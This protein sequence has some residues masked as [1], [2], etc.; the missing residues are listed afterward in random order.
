MDDEAEH[1]TDKAA[2]QTDALREVHRRAMQRFDA[3]AI[4]TMENR[5][6]SLLARRF[7]TIP[8]AQWDGDWGVQFEKSI[9]VEVNKVGRGVDKIERDYRDNR[10]VPDFRPD[11]KEA[12]DETADTLDGMHRAD[13]YRF[14]SQQARDNAA[15]EAIAG[16]FG[17]Y[18]MSNEW[19][20]EDDRDNDHQRINPASIIT[21][22]DQSVFFD[23]NARLYDKSDAKYAFI[24]ISLSREAFE[25]EYGDSASDFPENVLWK[26]WDWFRPDTVAVA[27]YYVKE[28]T[29]DT[30]W[31]LTNTISGEEQRVWASEIEDGW[32][33][34]QVKDGWKKRSQRRKR[35]RVHKYVLSGA[36]VLEDCG[37]IAGEFIPVV[38]IYGKRYFVEGIE[39]WKGYVQDKMD[40][41]RLYNSM[42]SKLAETNS[43]APREVPL[44][45][46]E[47]MPPAL[48]SHWAN[49]NIERHAYGLV[50]P[51]RDEAGQIVSAGP[52]GKIDPP[53][54]APVT[55]TLLQ[56][57]NGDLTEDMVDGSDTVRANTSAEAMDL[58]AT[59]VDAKS[60]IYLDNI[61]QSVQR[62][63]E[64]YLSIAQEVYT[65]EGREVETMDEEGGTGIAKLKKM[66]A[67]ENGESKVINDLQGARYKVIVS[68]TE[69]TATRRDKTVKASLNVAEVANAAGDMELAQA[70]IL[71][72]VMNM[73]GEGMSDLKEYARKRAIAIGVAKPNEE[74][75][76]TMDE[77]AQQEQPDPMAQLATAQADDFAAGAEKKRAEVAKV[78]A[79]TALSKA[80]TLETL[81]GLNQPAND[82]P[83]FMEKYRSVPA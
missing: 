46:P 8:G 80:K 82:S 52:V 62:E 49:M 57:A 61:R 6:E 12:N 18:R 63:G 23:I 81:H 17:A 19:D 77:A 59:R 24:R 76:R 36:E 60:G 22:A 78:E 83:P 33:T 30:L 35:C 39:R 13:S 51:L 3:C 68:V 28:E 9:R 44:F 26:A 79:D 32:L 11:G 56:V 75:Q 48:A 73:D 2:E 21:D 27:E 10:I 16:G 20:D 14:K 37:L 42:V 31:I 58:A 50:E 15:F 40:S 71:T 67:N 72:A 25:E 7:I 4:P 41:Q 38:P 55:A 53:Q 34:Q 29:K 47:Q 43:L 1:D 66:V 74:E 65:E 54:L 64:I 5:A 69:A 70:S 45:A